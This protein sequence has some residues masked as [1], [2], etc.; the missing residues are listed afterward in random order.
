MSNVSDFIIENGVLEEYV[1][2]SR[3]VTIPQGVVEIGSN[4]FSWR[5]LYG[6]KIPDG[7]RIIGSAAFSGND[8]TSVHLPASIE[9]IGDR[10][11]S[12]CNCLSEVVM[13]EGVKHI[14]SEAFSNCYSLRDISIPESVTTIGSQAFIDT[15]WYKNQLNNLIFAGKVL[16]YCCNADAEM[17]IPE[18]TKGIAARAFLFQRAKN[19]AKVII[20]ASV[21]AIGEGAFSDCNKL[22]YAEI[23]G[24][25]E[26]R[27][28]CFSKK[29]VI[30]APQ[31]SIDDV[32]QRFMKKQVAVGYFLRKENE[33]VGE[34]VA[35]SVKKYVQKNLG[36]LRQD[37]EE[38]PELLRGL[39]AE[40]MLLPKHVDWLLE[41]F[42][43]DAEKIA[44][45]LSYGQGSEKGTIYTFS[46]RGATAAELK[47]IWKTE[48]LPDGTLVIT[49]YRGL[50][51]TVEVPARI[52]KKL[53]TKIGEYSFS[54]SFLTRSLAKVQET[55]LNIETIIIPDGVTTIGDCAFDGCESL[56]SVTLPEG[57][58]SI[59]NEAFRGCVSLK[60]VT[61]PNGVTEI[62]WLAFLICESLESIT[63]PASV[64]SIG[65]LAFEGCKS[66]RSIYIPA[67]VKEIK[68]GAFSFSSLKSIHAPAG[69]YA[70]QYAKEHNIPFVAE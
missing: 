39:V 63:I 19:M 62:G 69:S 44:L 36:E 61:I 45:L 68:N 20:P 65:N 70:E 53:V 52:G 50:D 11:F 35:E 8:M 57:M 9:Q 22:K 47:K 27:K 17:V 34:G 40:K 14:G 2:R 56:K 15:A 5:R 29:T 42:S 23:L 3:I 38:H 67:S 18:G 25:P 24:R 12:T 26:M 16:L 66:L 55:R 6:I 13:Q 7:V 46:Q 60:S 37:I 43:G 30:T 49:G 59:G 58:T 32:K 21:E 28:D 48:P 54:P 1:G 4:A 31:I 51:T 10:A 64:T 41:T 33:P